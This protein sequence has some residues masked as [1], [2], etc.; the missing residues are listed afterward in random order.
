MTAKWQGLEPVGRV[1]DISLTIDNWSWVAMRMLR[2]LRLT[3]HT[4]LG[5]QWRCGPA[6]PRNAWMQDSAAKADA[7]R[8]ANF[9]HS[10]AGALQVFLP[11][12]SPKML[13]NDTK[14]FLKSGKVWQVLLDPT[15]ASKLIL[16]IYTLSSLWISDGRPA[17][18]REY[19]LPGALAEPPDGVK[20]AFLAKKF[21]DGFPYEKSSVA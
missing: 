4:T 16:D 14:E 21:A 17:G 7:Y 3:D 10:G 6:P 5:V 15:I 18:R 13:L 2:S 9:D 20:L 1:L 11:P 12:I 8:C 19:R